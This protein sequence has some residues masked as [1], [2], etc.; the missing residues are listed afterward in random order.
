MSRAVLAKSWLIFG[1]VALLV[2]GALS[3]L[4]TGA[5]MPFVKPLLGNLEWIRWFL[6]I[7][8]NLATLVWF[9][10]I[11]VG[12]SHWVY[13]YQNESEDRFSTRLGFIGLAT[14]V[15]G[16]LLMI[17]A[18]PQDGV[19]SILSNYI[20][21][22]THF[23]HDLGLIFYLLGVLLN[24]ANL[25]MLLPKTKVMND[26]Y[27]IR[28]G[29][30]VGAVY[31]ILAVIALATS[32]YLLNPTDYL[33]PQGYYEVLMWGGGHMLQH[34]STVFLV[35]FC[36]YLARSLTEDENVWS[37]QRLFPVFAG[38]AIP[39]LI[40]PLLFYFSPVDSIYR[41][42]FTQLMMWGLAPFILYFIYGTFR[43]VG[44]KRLLNIR[45][46][47]SVGLLGSFFLIVMGSLFG[48]FIRGPDLRVP[49]HYHATIGAITVIFFIIAFRTLFQNRTQPLLTG[50][51]L[52]I[53]G[54]SLFA[55]GMFI[56]GAF[57]IGR[58]TYGAEHVLDHAGQYVG[59]GMLG[60]GGVIALAGGISL[61][62]AVMR[63]ALRRVSDK[64]CLPDR[65]A[66]GCV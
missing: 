59:F 13:R 33:H 30:W 17:S 14:S 4:V 29:L 63:Q 2:S 10:S 37:R 57:G 38:L 62:L 46:P 39:S 54:Q 16:V 41:Q 52:Y 5:K 31:F 1:I 43:Q 44:T 40:A 35:S 42:G 19:T 7:H 47:R 11:P 64:Q 53:V 50:V 49:G 60:V 51:W 9:T 26:W 6:V 12:I 27:H 24:Y 45:D 21:V 32:F 34:S 18:T 36:A 56:A 15:L 58:K 22:V 20:P 65:A 25:T 48:A 8:V 61:G 3:V 28:F 66:K 55:S 23:R